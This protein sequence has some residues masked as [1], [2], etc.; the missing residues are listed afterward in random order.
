MGGGLGRQWFWLFVYEIDLVLS[1]LLQRDD[2][3]AARGLPESRSTN[4]YPQIAAG[5]SAYAAASTPVTS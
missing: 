1:R 5:R 4:R 2:V 3:V